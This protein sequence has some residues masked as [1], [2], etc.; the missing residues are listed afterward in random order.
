MGKTYNEIIFRA[1]AQWTQRDGQAED[2]ARKAFLE[3]LQLQAVF[4]NTAFAKYNLD[5]KV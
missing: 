4:N 1:T 2:S 3:K 5:L